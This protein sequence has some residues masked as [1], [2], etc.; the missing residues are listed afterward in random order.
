MV[1]NTV[2]VVV[3]ERIQLVDMGNGVNEFVIEGLFNQFGRSLVGN[4]DFIGAVV[5]FK[6][7]PGLD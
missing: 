5:K 3:L 4:P 2:I 6:T 7:C 1:V